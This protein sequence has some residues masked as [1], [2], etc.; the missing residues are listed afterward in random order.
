MRRDDGQIEFG[1]EANGGRGQRIVVGVARAL[2]FEVVALGKKPGPGRRGLGRPLRVALAEASPTS[3][4]RKPESAIRPLRAFGEPFAL[5]L[6]AAAILVAAIRAGQPV[7]ELEIAVARLAE[8]QQAIRG[9]ALGVVR[10][11]HVASDDRLDAGL[12]RGSVE[13]DHAED[14]GQVGERQRRHP[15]GRRR[16]HRGVDAH[17]AVDDRI[18]AVQAQMNEAGQRLRRSP[19]RGL[20]RC[21]TVS[22]MTSLSRRPTAPPRRRNRIGDR[23]RSWGTILLVLSRRFSAELS[24]HFV[25][26]RT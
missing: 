16:G 5:H 4:P 2:H 10:D 25:G 19:A 17:H 20:I 13:L 8:Q 9:V 21:E 26:L 18:F 23:A 22:A 6:R 7:G 3:P 11:P 14:V 24:H 15:V 12:A 1:G